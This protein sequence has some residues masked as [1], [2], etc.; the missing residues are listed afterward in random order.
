Q[1]GLSDYYRLRTSPALRPD[2]RR[3]DEAKAW[4]RPELMRH[5]VRAI[6]GSRCEATI[7]V[8]GIRCSACVWLI[9]RAL[10][11]L[12]GLISLQINPASRRARIVWDADRA[13]LGDIV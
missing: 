4:R 7:Y 8:E 5:V 10:S 6:D 1:L 9:D 3:R 2:D 13:E 12:P 11:A